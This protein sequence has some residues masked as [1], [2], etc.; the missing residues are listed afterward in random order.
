MKP[1]ITCML[2]CFMMAIAVSAQEKADIVVSYDEKIPGWRTDSVRTSRMSLLANPRGAKY[3]NDLSLWSDSLSS[4]PEGKKQLNQIIMAACMTET[5]GGGITMDMRKGPVKKIHTYVFTSMP[6]DKLTYY[7]KFGDSEGYYDEPLDEMQWE[8]GDSTAVILGY[9]CQ[10]ATTDYHGRRW[11]AWFTTDIPLPFGPW[12]FHGLPGLILKAEADPA[13]VFEAT[14]IERSDRLMTPIYSPENYQRTNR[15]KALA[16][17]E[18][19][20]NN[21]E[22]ILQA[23][24]GGKVELNPGSADRP[25]YNAAK[26][27]LEPDYIDR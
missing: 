10:S 3:F 13:F 16:D 6:D 15:K 8:I 22:A 18:Y 9:E 25:K 20:L 21:L 23:K 4:T 14:G 12:K 1:K 7:G 11:T 24:F 27:S 19:Y 26:Y 5:P 2:L 17:D